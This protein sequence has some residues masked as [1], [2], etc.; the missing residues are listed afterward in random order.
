[1]DPKIV[2]IGALL[3]ITVS[4]LVFWYT[5]ASRHR[6]DGRVA[7]GPL[8]LAS[9]FVSNFF[10]QLGIGSFGTTPSMYRL[11]GLVRDEKIPG[12]LNVGHTVPTVIQAVIYTQIIEVDFMTLALLIAAAVGG[13][14]LGAGI[15]A[16]LPRRKIQVGMGTALIVA[17]V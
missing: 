3:A 12:T 13:S 17:A 4:Y 7:L 15:V 10:D 9:G 11:W 14:W 1:M 2:L 16:G 6:H 8:E 5:V